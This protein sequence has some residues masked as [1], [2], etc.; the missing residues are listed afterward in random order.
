MSRPDPVRRYLHRVQHVRNL[1]PSCYVLR[2]DRNDIP[3]RAGQC[4]SVGIKGSGVNREYS[5]YSGE[6]DD[7]LEFLIKEIT[8]GVVSP[9]LKHLNVGDVVDVEGPYSDFVLAGPR[10]RTRK[11][12][13]ICTGTGI[14]PFHSY[15]KT[16]PTLDYTLLHGVRYLDERYDSHVFSGHYIACVSR[17]P[18]G[19]FTGRVTAYLRQNDVIPYAFFYLCGNR[20]MI[21]E[22]FDILRSQTVS[23]DHILTEVFF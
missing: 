13:F 19:D 3:F 5:I 12:F 8:P 6:Q 11:H 18:G 10:D 22:A 21:E 20:A 17:E 16:Y 15:V 4:V 7:Y 1:T 14:A 9:A 2:V 23:S